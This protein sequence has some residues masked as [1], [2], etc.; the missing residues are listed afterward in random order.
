MH[1]QEIAALALNG[2]YVGNDWFDQ[3]PSLKY[4]NAVITRNEL[5]NNSLEQYGQSYKFEAAESDTTEVAESAEELEEPEEQLALRTTESHAELEEVIFEKD[6]ISKRIGHDIIEWLTKVYKG[7]RGF[8]LGTFDSSLLA[9]TMK[10]QS[11]KWEEIAL[12]YISDVVTMA[13]TFIVD[14]FRLVCPNLRV[15]EGLMSILMDDLMAKY[16][17]AFDSARLL[18]RLE[19]MGTPI[20]LNHYFNDNLEK[21]YVALRSFPLV[22][23]PNTSSVGTVV[24]VQ[25]W[26]RSV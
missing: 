22:A 24:C 16:K 3:Y 12:A 13:H 8:E 2:N 9:M 23:K 17:T 25:L 20:T 18:L 4:A 21:R 15:R 14:L 19:R 7:S 5:F 26:R 6:T 10:A 1:F 11:S